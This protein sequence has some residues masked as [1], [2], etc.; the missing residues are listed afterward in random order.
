VFSDSHDNIERLTKALELANKESVD[1]IFFCGDLVS[2]FTISLI[3]GKLGKNVKFIGVWGNNEGD[4]DTIILRSENLS[5]GRDVVITNLDNYRLLMLHG[6][7][8]IETTEILV[9]SLLKSLD[10]DIIL[11]GHTHRAKLI[12]IGKETREIREINILE[13]LQSQKHPKEFVIDLSKEA[14][15]V[16]PG[17]LCGYLSGISTVTI[18]HI[19]GQKLG[20]RYIRIDSSA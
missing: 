18:L 7:D 16:N 14:V 2:P 9:K 13:I 15:A 12:V 19:N 8:D 3:T 11:F 20:I 5:Y 4:R 10:Y 17:E 6:V 1:K